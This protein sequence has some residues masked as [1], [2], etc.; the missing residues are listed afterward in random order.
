[1]SRLQPPPQLLQL[2][3]QFDWQPQD[4]SQQLL[5]APQLASQPQEASQQ[6]LPQPQPQ[7]PPN[8]LS[9]MEQPPPQQLDEQASQQFDSQP[10]LA[11]Q[12]QLDCAQQLASALH[13]FSQQAQLGSQPQPH[14]QPSIR[15][16]KPMPKLGL[17]RAMLNMS[18]PK[19][20]HFIEH[21]L[22]LCWNHFGQG[23]LP[24]SGNARCRPTP[25][26]RP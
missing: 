1:S 5:F 18:A 22:L 12:P 26:Y 15:S 6:L 14:P 17:A 13:D 10:Q 20:F 16:S 4:A 21:R 24:T 3:Q 11:S 19:K 9:R 23:C 25:N 2:L 7:N 8:R